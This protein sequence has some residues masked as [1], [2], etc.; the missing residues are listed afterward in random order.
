MLPLPPYES[1]HPCLSVPVTEIRILAKTI[2][3]ISS[4]SIPVFFYLLR[5]PISWLNPINS[6]SISLPLKNNKKF[7]QFQV[8]LNFRITAKWSIQ[9]S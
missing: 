5:V 7:R 6:F 2:T 1:N 9:K 8:E 4:N 3:Y